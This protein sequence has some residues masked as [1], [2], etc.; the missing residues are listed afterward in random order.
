[1]VALSF[2]FADRGRQKRNIYDSHFFVNDRHIKNNL[3]REKERKRK[4]KRKRERERERD[5][6]TERER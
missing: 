4:R 2:A 6:Q 1:M 5:R 3:E